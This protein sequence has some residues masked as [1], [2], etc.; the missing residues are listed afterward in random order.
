MLAA[1]AIAFAGMA[2]STKPARA[3]AEDI[4]RFLAGAVI[5]GAIVNAIDDH[6]TPRYYGSSALP[7]SCMET[8]R[9]DWRNIQVYNKRCLNRGNYHGLPQRCERNFRVNG[10]NRRGYVAQ[11]L[12]D[13]GFTRA[14]GW[15]QPPRHNNPPF[16]PSPP[17]YGHSDR[18]PTSCL[19]RYR[20]NGRSI[21]GYWA[22]CLRDSGF[23]NMPQNCRLRTRDGDRL[24]NAPCLYNAGHRNWGDGR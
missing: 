14:N 3:N 11:C 13:A 5:V 17:T 18:L 15:S 2:A 4:L 22:S 6:H 12:W 24:F 10:R 20:Q 23:R 16:V 7:D 8:V 19:M 9:V 21:Q 1:V